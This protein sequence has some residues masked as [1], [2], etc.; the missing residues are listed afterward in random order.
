MT[1]R[2]PVLWKTKFLL[3]YPQFWLWFVG[4]TISTLGTNVS[5]IV[6][7]WMVLTIT[8]SAIQSSLTAALEFV[9]YLLFSILAGIMADKWDRKGILIWTNILRAFLLFILPCLF[10]IHHLNMVDIYGVSFMNAT[11]SVLSNA[12]KSSVVPSVFPVHL[13]SRGN[14][15]MQWG[16]AI[17]TMLG[18][19]LGGAFMAIMPA[20]WVLSF[21]ALSYLVAAFCLWRMSTPL[22]QRTQQR[23]TPQLAGRPLDGLRFV[24]RDPILRTMT[25]IM[26]VSNFAN[27]ASFSIL[28]F[29][30]RDVLHLA[31]SWT[32]FILGAFG[33][34][35]FLGASSHGVVSQRMNTGRIFLL[36]RAAAIVPMVLFAVGSAPVVLVIASA[37]NGVW[38]VFWNIESATFR[39]LHVPDDIRGRVSSVTT[40]LAWVMIPVGAMFGGWLAERIGCVLVFGIAAGLQGVNLLLI[41]KSGLRKIGAPGSLTLD[42]GSRQTTWT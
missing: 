10:L 37:V 5:L 36:S 19:A 16:N 3:D 13:L 24:L 18:P 27:F 29:F 35:L 11:L 14:Q 38:M 42:S 30:S 23:D 39:Q 31:A 28:V 32:A 6:I 15:F 17:S 22:Q 40:M 41:S 34:G 4:E 12:A 21:D 20:P 8:H 25:G 33:A 1:H 7:P 9:P 2:E 26:S